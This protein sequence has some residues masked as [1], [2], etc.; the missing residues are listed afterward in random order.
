MTGISAWAAS[1][2]ATSC[3]PVRTTIAVDEPI[4]I[5]GH[6]ADALAG[7]QDRVVG[8]V[9]RVT[10]E[11]DHPGLE[12]DPRPQTRLLEQHRQR[13]PGQRQDVVSAVR[14]ELRLE[15]R[16]RLEDAPDLRRRQVR[17][18]QQIPPTQRLRVVIVTS[19]A[20]VVVKRSADRGVQAKAPASE[21]AS[22]PQG[23]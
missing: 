5:T 10:A 23:A 20:G 6:V 15:H 13:P 4:E 17:D 8:Q 18:T 2:S 7:A 12:R 9:D 3:G 19:A 14:A 16:R 22:A 11:L 1:S 21:G